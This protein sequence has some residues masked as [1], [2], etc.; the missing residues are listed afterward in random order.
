MFRPKYK[1]IFIVI[2]FIV[3]LFLISAS[4]WVW[5]VSR[6]PDLEGTACRNCSR[7]YSSRGIATAT[8][9]ELR[10][11]PEQFRGKLIRV[12]AKFHNDA[13]LLG[14]IDTCSGGRWMHAGF[15]NSF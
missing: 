13:G 8:V 7:R 5:Y 4:A 3:V 2:I 11:N 6:V 15:S 10:K 12:R 14:L 1:S 9:C